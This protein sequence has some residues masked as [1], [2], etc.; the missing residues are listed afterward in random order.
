MVNDQAARLRE[1]LM[2]LKSQAKS[3]AVVSGKGGVGKS[4]L[5]R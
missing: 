2:A 4:K 5:F 1:R 3:I